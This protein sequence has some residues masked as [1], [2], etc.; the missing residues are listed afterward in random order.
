M[1]FTSVALFARD[2]DPPPKDRILSHT[3][4]ARTADTRHSPGTPYD[5]G[6]VRPK[7]RSLLLFYSL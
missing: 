2:D 4:V 3:V 1:F 6:S 7:V 5:V